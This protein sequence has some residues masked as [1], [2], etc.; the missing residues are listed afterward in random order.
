[1]KFYGFSEGQTRSVRIPE[2][3]FRELLLE[4]DDP[5]ELRL[6]L[7][8][9]WRLERMEGTFR[10]LRWSSLLGDKNLLKSYASMA[11]LEQ[12]LER[13]VARGVLLTANL[14][15]E[16]AQERM[17]F[18][19]NPRGQAALQ[20]IERGDWRLTGDDRQP[21]AVYTERPNIFQ[22]Y[23]SNIGTLTPM[24]AE[25]LQDAE[26]TYPAEWIEDAIRI[27]VENNKRSWRY[28]EA[29]LRRWQ[30]GGRDGK[31]KDTERSNERESDADRRDSAE[32]RRRYGEWDQER[33]D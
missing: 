30:E 7:Y 24:I 27:S 23:E 28:A 15:V 25:A 21:L 32:A 10:Y 4:M 33:H 8:V 20:A 3:F 26:K 5:G 2:Q 6:I 14:P 18:L 9:F 19:N 31:K 17:I 11:E 22:L 29:I 13:A 16:D 12:S 1:M